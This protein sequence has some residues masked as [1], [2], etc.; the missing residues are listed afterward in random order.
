V[1]YHPGVLID[2]LVY[3]LHFLPII[4]FALPVLYWIFVQWRTPRAWAIGFGV[5]AAAGAAVAV[6]LLV[7]G[8]GQA[9]R[10]SWSLC[11]LGSAIAWTKGY[12]LYYPRG[13]GPMLEQLYGPVSA[14]IYT[15]TAIAARPTIAAT[16]GACIDAATFLLPTGWFLLAVGRRS[17]KGA[18]LAAWVALVLMAMRQFVLS[19]GATRVTIDMPATGFAIAALAVLARK[20]TSP[21]ADTPD[22]A[23]GAADASSAPIPASSIVPTGLLCGLFGGL[24]LWCKFTL[25]P[26]LV[27]MPL[28][29]L[30]CHGWRLTLRFTAA[31]LA[32]IAVL[33]TGL[34]LWLGPEMLF[35]TLIIPS[36]Q[37]LQWPGMDRTAAYLRA[38]RWMWLDARPIGALSIAAM[39]LAIVACLPRPRHLRR[40]L[41]EQVWVLPLLTGVL[42]LPTTIIARA[43]LGAA[44]NH[45]VPGAT[46]FLLAGVAALLIAGRTMAP[47]GRLA[48]IGILVL[49]AMHGW[50]GAGA[51]EGLKPQLAD[52]AHLSDNENEQAYEMAR[53]HPGEFYFPQHPV[54]SLL[55]EGKAYHFSVWLDDFEWAGYPISESQLRAYLPKQM[56]SIFYR[57]GTI[58]PNVLQRLPEFDNVEVSPEFPGW[59]R[60]TRDGG[61]RAS[62]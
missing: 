13:E 61:G 25:G 35:Q 7:A 42:V 37:P 24:A 53:A 58:P 22:P 23:A 50:I 10:H 52:W 51:R 40:W 8:I 6:V 54:S 18:T 39:L 31:M 33:S 56:H 4:L 2:L 28:Y 46:L 32:V 27:A 19:E 29:L 17:G 55:A 3:L 5:F 34:I 11:R 47:M 1:S 59:V 14:L 45:V 62:E 21:T 12:R 38:A 15:P 57:R 48:R 26:V 49:I 41:T 16:I 44:F 43:K 30:I 36:R 20:L 9:S 60:V